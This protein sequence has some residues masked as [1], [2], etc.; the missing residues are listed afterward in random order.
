MVLTFSGGLPILYL[1]G[2]LHYLG[3]FWSYKFFFLKYYRKTIEFNEGLPMYVTKMF[4]LAI[5]IHIVV[6]FFMLT[7]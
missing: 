1:I 4:K 7:N 2:F 3:L 5:F 6:T